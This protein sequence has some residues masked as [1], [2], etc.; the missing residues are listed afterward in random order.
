MSVRTHMAVGIALAVIAG[1][2]AAAT[3]TIYAQANGAGACQ[4]AL[5]NYEGQIRK[6]PL[7]I[8]NEGSAGAFI[9]CS[10]VSLQGNALHGTGHELILINNTN[11]TKT[12]NCT[13]VSGANY[14]PKSVQVPGNGQASL[15]WLEADGVGGMNLDTMNMSC[16]I[17]PGIGIRTLYTRQIVDVGQ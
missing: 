4:G 3:R 11:V 7:A 1:S 14:M 9:T 16:L 17:P 15:S 8:Q 2:S 5:P 6:R 13:G 12:V 10:P